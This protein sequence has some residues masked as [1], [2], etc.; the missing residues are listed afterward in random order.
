MKRI[1]NHISQW[2][3]LTT[4]VNQRWQKSQAPF[5]VTIGKAPKTHEQL[6]YLHAEVLPKLAEALY[7][8]G[9]TNNPSELAAKYWLKRQIGYGN[10]YIFGENVVFDPDSFQRATIETIKQAI[11][12]A[13]DESAKRGIVI[14]P[15][16]ESHARV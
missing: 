15:P 14:N 2:V 1:I 12:L 13:V 6:G 11:D 3:D 10:Y 5:T 4:K 16:K 8:T 9:E 7:D